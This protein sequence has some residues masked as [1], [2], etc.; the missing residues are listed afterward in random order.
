[1]RRLLPTVQRAILVELLANT[2]LVTAVVTG[3]FFVG[4]LLQFMVRNGDLA[5]E[6]ILTVLPHLLPA[7]FT[8]TVPSSLLL[9]TIMTFGRMGEDQE[10]TALRAC[11][12]SLYHVLLPAVF[13]GVVA[14]GICFVVNADLLPRSLSAQNLIAKDLLATIRGRLEQARTN[15]YVFDRVKI[16]WERIDDGDLIGLTLVETSARGD[17]RGLSQRILEAE[18]GRISLDADA[19]LLVFDLTGV[20][21]TSY[22]AEGRASPPSEAERVELR[23]HA[24]ELGR[25]RSRY[26]AAELPLRDLLYVALRG[27]DDEYH[28]ISA[29]SIEKQ[30]HLRL[31]L[32]LAPLVMVFVGAPIGVLVGRSGVVTASLVAF[33]FGAMPFYVMLLGFQALASAERL[34]SAFI[35]VSDAVMLLFGLYLCRRAIRG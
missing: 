13:V 6:A 3:V 30:V 17:D 33:L 22:D 20:R 7:L 5:I 31:A 14:S 26:R 16:A 28:R 23:V 12:V 1:M 25:R 10:V 29:T 18:R 2:V 34:D 32:A 4:S 27:G 24:S 15:S 21:D 35:W 11:G 8:W 19:E 9:A